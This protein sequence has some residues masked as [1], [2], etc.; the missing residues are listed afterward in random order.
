MKECGEYERTGL[1]RTTHS[2]IHSFIHSFTH[3][4]IRSVSQSDCLS[5]IHFLAPVQFDIPTTQH[6]T[7]LI[8]SVFI[9]LLIWNSRA[10]KINPV[11]ICVSVIDCYIA[12]KP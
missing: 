4:F 9:T 5:V 8:T 10:D 11:S 6:L 3:P 2:L 12:V 7:Q 1:C